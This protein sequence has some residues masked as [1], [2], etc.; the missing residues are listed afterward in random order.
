MTRSFKFRHRIG[1]LVLLAATGLVTVTA[2]TLVLGRRGEQQLSG[3]ETRYVP[4]IELDRDLKSIIARLTRALEDAAAAA[5]ETKLSEAD[6]LDRDF[7][8]R[9]RTGADSIID[10]GGDP[11][12]L[13]AQ[14]GVYYAIAREVSAAIV[15]GTSMAELGTRIDKM[16]A[17]QATF[18]AQLDTT[19]SP[20]RRRL[21][22]A[23]ATARESQRD[24]LWIEIVV[25]SSALSLMSLLSWGII[26]RT[27]KHLRSVSVGVERLAAG[28]F[29]HEIDVGSRDE[30]GDLAREANRTAVRL[31]EYRTKTQT[32]LSETQRQAEELRHA[33]TTLVSAQQ[34]LEERANELARVSRYKSQFLANMSH[35]LRTPLNSIMIL[36]KVLSENAG[37]TL[38]EKQVELA[39]LINKSGEELLSLINEVLDLA[40]VEAG[41]QMLDVAPVPVPDILEYMRRMFDP[42]AAQ[43]QLTFEVG[44]VG[45]LPAEIRTDW[46]RL[47][48]ILKNLLSNALKFTQRGKVEARISCQLPAIADVISDPIVISVIDTGIGIA[49]DKH[50]FV[51]EAFAQAETGTSRKFGGTGLGLTIAKQLSIRLGGNLYVESELDKGST[52]HV[53]LSIAGPPPDSERAPRAQPAPAKTPA[54]FA[55]KAQEPIAEPAYEPDALLAGKTVMLIDDDMRNVYS[56]SSALRAKDLRVITASDVPEALEQLD[57]HPEIDLVIVD[58]TIASP[59]EREIIRQLRGR[60]R[61]ATLP[62]IALTTERDTSLEAGASECLPKP[63]EVG[64][65]IGLLR[66][67]LHVS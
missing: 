56:L 10:N 65:L 49:D 47:A 61:F 11:V 6:D 64:K 29:G 24:A 12:A 46:A 31:R 35:E 16:R 17:A 3:I 30:I 42:L 51:F 48:Q 44:G 37:H 2:V 50:A 21:A 34:L 66:I 14:L 36:S 58:L 53:V 28:D 27:V 15:G 5:D 63:V 67:L 19:T 62:V 43:K 59:R 52:F 40:K 22:A 13:E 4:L 41:K 39:T 55:L 7:V 33:N 26:R 45:A 8:A 38:T 1:L 57:N 9:L 20:D 60:P 32:L 25:A 23:F 54:L 18:T